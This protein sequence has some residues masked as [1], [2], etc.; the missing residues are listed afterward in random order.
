[1]LAESGEDEKFAQEKCLNI[2]I[3]NFVINLN[4]MNSDVENKYFDAIDIWDGRDEI[5][6]LRFLQSCSSHKFSPKSS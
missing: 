2:Y 6:G 3:L 1:M 5:L 4:I